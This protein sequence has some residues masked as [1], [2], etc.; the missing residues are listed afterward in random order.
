MD[1]ASSTNVFRNTK[2][3]DHGI[4][5]ILEEQEDEFVCNKEIEAP[6]IHDHQALSS[7]PEL[8]SLFILMAPVSEFKAIKHQ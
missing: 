2:W 6:P 8:S 3:Q 7:I 1:V 4:I 5:G